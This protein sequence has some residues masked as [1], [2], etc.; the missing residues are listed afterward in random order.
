V[1]GASFP[2][3]E[4]RLQLDHVLALG[5][6]VTGRDA[7]VRALPVGDHRALTVAVRAV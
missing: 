2:A 4:P 3:H 1:A 6:A 7:A 5:R